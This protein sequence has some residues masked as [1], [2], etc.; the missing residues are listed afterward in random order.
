[1]FFLYRLKQEE[2]GKDIVKTTK[3]KKR[4]EGQ[5]VLFNKFFSNSLFFRSFL[6]NQKGLG[7]CAAERMSALLG[8]SGFCKLRFVPLVKLK[9]VEKIILQRFIALKVFRRLKEKEE[10]K[11]SRRNGYRFIRRKIGYPVRGQETKRNAKTARKKEWLSFD[12]GESR[13]VTKKYVSK[14][15]NLATTISLQYNII[16]EIKDDNVENEVGSIETKMLTGFQRYKERLKKKRYSN[17][18]KKKKRR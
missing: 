9:K 8:F 16:D 12:E 17:V 18:K 7:V 14:K 6:E 1:M 11:K 5:I 2:G 4:E 13:N 3:R 15:K 10:Y